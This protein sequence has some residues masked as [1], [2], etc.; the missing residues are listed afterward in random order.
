VTVL[1]HPIMKSSGS[2]STCHPWYDWTF[3]HSERCIGWFLYRFLICISPM[4]QILKFF[5]VFVMCISFGEVFLQKTL[6]NFQIVLFFESL[7]NYIFSI[8]ILRQA[9][10]FQRFSFPSTR[11]FS[12]KCLSSF[13]FGRRSFMPVIPSY[14]GGLE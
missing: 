6:L 11:H 2:C 7:I 10:A 8:Q 9:K 1:S 14:I 3:S 12:L 5:K 4:I 13:Q